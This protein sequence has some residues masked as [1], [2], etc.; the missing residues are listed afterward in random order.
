MW[1]GARLTVAWPAAASASLPRWRVSLAMRSCRVASTGRFVRPNAVQTGRRL[2]L[3]R[4]RFCFPGSMFPGFAELVDPG[5]RALAGF[6]RRF[7]LLRAGGGGFGG[8]LHDGLR[9]TGAD[10]GLPVAVGL[11]GVFGGEL[12]DRDVEAVGGADVAGDAAGVAGAGV[13]AGE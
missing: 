5:C 9:L 11:V 7:A 12:L 8:G 1:S 10:E 3:C 13:A 2:H 6:A 4:R